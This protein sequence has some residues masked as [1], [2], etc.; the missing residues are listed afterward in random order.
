MNDLK[1]DKTALAQEITN[2]KNS[3]DWI[4]NDTDIQT[5]IKNAEEINEQGNPTYENITEA[6]NKLANKLKE[7]KDKELSRQ[8][9]AKQAVADTEKKLDDNKADN[10]K[11][12]EIDLK[13]IEKVVEE[14]KDPA[15]KE[16]L[17]QKIK[18][19]KESIANKQKKIE[20]DKAQKANEIAKEKLAQN[21]KKD[22][23]SPKTGIQRKESRID[24][25]SIIAF[26]ITLPSLIFATLRKI[27]SQ[28]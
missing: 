6:A 9:H 3:P 27:I 16:K 11:L 1:F 23:S 20:D 18:F 26:S 24:I 22:L 4:K 10:N 8:N 5:E 21:T 17:A 2:F 25:L 14:V 19:I 12:P 28:N 13:E 7:L 15:E